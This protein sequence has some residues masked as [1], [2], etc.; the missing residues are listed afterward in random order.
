MKIPY[1]T[2][3]GALTKMFAASGLSERDAAITSECLVRT[4]GKG[5]YSHGVHLVKNYIARVGDHGVAPEAKMT[6]VSESPSSVRILGNNGMGQVHMTD[7]TNMAIAKAKE[8][9]ACVITGTGIRHYG[10]GLVFADMCVAENMMVELYANSITEVA[11][12]GSKERYYGTNPVT[13][14]VPAGKYHPYILDMACSVGAGNKVML[15]LREGKPVPE[16]WGIDKDGKPTTDAAAIRGGGA[17]LP[18]GGIKGSGLAGVAQFFAGV[19]SGAAKDVRD[20][21]HTS[22]DN[23]GFL[24]QVIDISKFMD[25]EEYNERIEYQ[26]EALMNLEP[27]DPARP[28]IYPG[29]L[30][31]ERLAKA[32]EEGIEV[33][34]AI[35]D[36][37]SEAAESVGLDFASLIA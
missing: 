30:E 34:G 27:V 2:L 3:Q 37:L 36:E 35:Y 24:L 33:E 25:I 19:A 12:F 7:I 14:G 4:S 20:V 16:G 5:V 10:A 18:F 22:W 21:F 8:T 13:W 1:E 28:V 29:Y 17:M 31:G 32:K 6:I 11:P 15:M 9:G 26:I 23:C